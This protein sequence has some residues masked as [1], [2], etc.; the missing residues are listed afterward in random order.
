[1]KYLLFHILFLCFISASWSQTYFNRSYNDSVYSSETATNI[2]L[3][4]NGGFLLPSVFVDIA[5]TLFYSGYTIRHLHEDG[6]EID[7]DT[8]GIVQNDFF[9]AN[10]AES[11]M[12]TNDGGYLVSTRNGAAYALKLNSDLSTE[13]ILGLDSI[14]SFYRAKELANEMFLI[15]G[16]TYST[17]AISLIW[18]NQNGTI[19]HSLEIGVFDWPSFY[20]LSF[21]DELPNGDLIFGGFMA[22]GFDGDQMMF[23][24]NSEGYIIWRKGWS[25]DFLDW[26]IWPI[27]ETQDQATIAFGHVDWVSNPNDVG[28][29]AFH[30][31]IGTMEIDLNTGDTS[32]V[33]LYPEEL[34]YYWLTDFVK[35]PDGG[36][37]ALGWDQIMNNGTYE[38]FIL[39]LDSNRQLE[40]KK[41]YFH[42]PFPDNDYQNCQGWDLEITADSGF[43]V[44]GI[45][46][47]YINQGK[48]MPW[49]FKTDAC[50]DL[51]WNN[52]GVISVSETE[53]PQ[54]DV[55]VF[56]NP[57]NDRVT[58][59]SPQALESIVISDASGRV[60]S[61]L[62]G[63]RSY[64]TNLDLSSFSKGLYLV[65]VVDV[66]GERSVTKIVLR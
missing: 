12:R 43:V 19:D 20:N 15:C 6:F 10:W 66:Y 51:V 30:G 26:T 39:K 41:N 54:N 8:L 31:R 45:W 56:P 57:A 63:Q 47:D 33:I 60:L 52:C 24:T 13:W 42:E 65:E 44:S 46:D 17:Q 59:R 27:I 11:S 64:S 29:D 50:G 22:Y 7:R 61:H 49:V 36:Y 14:S 53:A 21:V 34:F 40:W 35:T 28:R 55:E 62:N 32:N 1:M 37:A 5:D 58:V 4:E 25:F 9:L 2:M 16:F 38:T 3:D 23:R 48:Q 18:I